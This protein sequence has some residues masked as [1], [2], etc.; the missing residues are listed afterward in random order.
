MT[1]VALER[2]EKLLDSEG[3]LSN[4]GAEFFEQLTRQI[5]LNTPITGAGSPEGVVTAEPY[6][7]YIDTTGAAGSIQYRK[8]TGTGN[9]GWVL[10]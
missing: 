5:N 9:T 4:R 10:V 7:I 2:F 1:I 6:Q 3:T 8:M